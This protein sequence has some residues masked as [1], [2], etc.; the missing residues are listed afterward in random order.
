MFAAIIIDNDAQNWGFIKSDDT[1]NK[2]AF[3]KKLIPNMLAVRKERREKIKTIL[4]NEYRREDSAKIYEC[5]NTVIDEVYFKDSELEALAV[6]IW[7]RPDKES[8]AVFDEIESEELSVTM[9]D[10][11]SYI[12]GLINEYVR[13]PQYKRQQLFFKEEDELLSKACNTGQLLCFNYEGERFKVYAHIQAYQYTLQQHCFLIAY[14][15]T[16]S[17]ISSFFLEKIKNPYL[18]KKVYS[19]PQYIEDALTDYCN[20]PEYDEFS[21]LHI[22]KE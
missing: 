6:D 11:S 14:D 10:M 5:V 18:L 9:L 3:L 21:V 8:M 15:L 1:S 13:F 17:I 12:R 20:N 19:P 2:N 22:D 7:I 16:R 4:T